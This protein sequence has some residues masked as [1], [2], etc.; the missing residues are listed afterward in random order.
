MALAGYNAIVGAAVNSG[1]TTLEDRV[2]GLLNLS[3]GVVDTSTAFSGWT[4]SGGGGTAA[5]GAFT[6][7]GSS[8]WLA[9]STGVRYGTAFTTNTGTGI[10]VGASTNNARRD[11][12]YNG[13]LYQS[14]AANSR[15]GIETIGT[16][17]PM[18]AASGTIGLLPGFSTTNGTYSPYDFWFADAS[19]LFIAN[20][21]STNS[22]LQKWTFD[23]S[24]WSLIY[25]HKISL[26][27]PGGSSAANGIKGL[28]GFL[29]G[30]GDAIMF[31]TT[32]GANANLMLSLVDPVG[33]TNAASVIETQ[34]VDPSTL[35]L[36]LG[37]HGLAVESSRLGLRAL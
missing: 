7:D 33:N 37:V 28:T 15:S 23:G 34:L 22:G 25:D 20:D 1:S 2:V 11:I 32:V 6:T 18:T 14:E 9:A 36:L 16:G 13:Q 21:T 29:D 19:T 4:G 5:R 30:N 26:V 31:A 10:S 12:V 3:T 27:N 8:V 17:T 35:S 24:T